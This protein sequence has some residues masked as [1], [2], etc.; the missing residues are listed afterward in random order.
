MTGPG[1]SPKDRCVC[2]GV[3]YVLLT[4]GAKR[5][6]SIG[7]NVLGSGILGRLFQTLLCRHSWPTLLTV[8]KLQAVDST[9][10]ALSIRSCKSR[11][12]VCTGATGE[13]LDRVRQRAD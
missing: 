5:R 9:F 1:E 13:D 4:I 6:G 8:I 3:A 10:G 2:C 12:N 11:E 7:N